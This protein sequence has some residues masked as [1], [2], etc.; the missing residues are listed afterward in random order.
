[1][2]HP[3][4]DKWGDTS[5]GNS[6]SNVVHSIVANITM[7]AVDN[8]SLKYKSAIKNDIDYNRE[9]E[10]LEEKKIKLLSS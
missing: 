5:S 8:D 7:L 1:M 3:Q 10:K 4:A 2:R 9:I 6:S